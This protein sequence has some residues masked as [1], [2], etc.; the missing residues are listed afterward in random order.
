[1]GAKDDFESLY[2]ILQTHDVYATQE[3][4]NDILKLVKT[5]IKKFISDFYKYFS[6]ANLKDYKKYERLS[7]N[8]NQNLKLDGYSL[9]RFE[10]RNTSNLRCIY[11]IQNENNKKETILLCAFNEDASKNTGKNTYN[12]NIEKAISIYQKYKEK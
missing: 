3:F 7:L 1:M 4:K 10:Y 8:K 11:I 6:R 2:Q 12:Y 5:D 9:F